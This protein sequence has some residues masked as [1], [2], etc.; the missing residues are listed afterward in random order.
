[1]HSC[2]TM[3]TAPKYNQFDALARHRHLANKL[4]SNQINLE[5]EVQNSL[6]QTSIPVICVLDSDAPERTQRQTKPSQA[7]L[8]LVHLKNKLIKAVVTQAQAIVDPESSLHASDGANHIGRAMADKCVRTQIAS[9]LGY[10]T[11]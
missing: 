6:A 11:E 8:P 7:S 4:L 3:P 9:G 2:A 1:M 10:T 5:K